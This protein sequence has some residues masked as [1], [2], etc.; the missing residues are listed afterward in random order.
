MPCGLMEHLPSQLLHPMEVCD[1]HSDLLLTLQANSSELFAHPTMTGA[2][3][4]PL[5]R[6]G[7]T[8]AFY[9]MS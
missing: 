8:A 9:G 6:H 5:D 2:P 3:L 7:N 4:G 1:H